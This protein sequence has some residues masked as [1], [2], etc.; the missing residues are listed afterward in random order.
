MGK[1]RLRDRD[2]RRNDAMPQEG[3]ALAPSDVDLCRS[4]ALATDPGPWDITKVRR[5]RAYGFCDFLLHRITPTPILG[6]SP[7]QES[8]KVHSMTAILTPAPETKAIPADG[9]FLHKGFGN[10][11][12]EGPLE[13]API[14]DPADAA[15]AAESLHRDG[16][17][18]FRSVLSPTEVRDLR[19]YMDA[20]GGDDVQYN[21]PNWCFNKHIG[22][23]FHQRPELLNLTDRPRVLS[24]AQAVLG[25]DCQVT[26]GSLWVTGPGRSM[27]LH[28]DYQ[29][30]SL[31]ED[32]M[33]D[34]R[35]RLPM[36]ATTAHYYLDDLTLDYGPTTLVPGSHRAGRPPN[37]ETEWNGIKPRALLVK[38]GD[39][40]LFRSEIWHGAAMNKGPHRR[41]VI[42]VHYGNIFIQRGSVPLANREKWDPRGLAA[43]TPA[44]RQLFGEIANPQR[45][46]YIA[47]EKQSYSRIMGA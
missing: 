32:I 38:A 10:C 16:Y 2:P 26:G 3:P 31:P 30:V 6:S 4:C 21:V 24:A 47:P 18:V 25:N 34:P 8:A 23:S 45:G 33:A 19:T 35:V 1:S 44:Q 12:Y 13:A 43:L 42:Q 28:V 37:N 11:K 14:D 15:T 20:E 46:S 39:C 17:T 41:Y 29:P 9:H 22:A 5:D 40:M 36:F 7:P 27:G